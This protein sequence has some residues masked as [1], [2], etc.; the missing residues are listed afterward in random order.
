MEN[1]R[2]GDVVNAITSFLTGDLWFSLL[3]QGS[4]PYKY[5]I[6]CKRAGQESIDPY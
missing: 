1:P 6:K 2:L 5:G 3:L 4:P